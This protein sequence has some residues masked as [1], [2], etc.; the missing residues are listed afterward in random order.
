MPTSPLPIAV[1]LSGTGRSLKNLIERQQAG[2]LSTDIRLVIASKPSAGGL[3]YAQDAGIPTEVVIRTQLESDAAFGT[4][5]FNLLRSHQV[6][7]VVLAGFMKFVPIP[8]DFENRVINIHPSLIP[9]FCGPGL[10]G[11]HVHQ[12]VLDYGVKVTGCTVHFV[13]NQYDHGPVILQRTTTVQE[14]DTAETLAARVFALELAALPKAIEL[15]A[16]HRI[17]V[18]GRLVRI[19]PA[20]KPD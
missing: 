10:Y 13:N 5:I 7:L 4:A 8:P 2:A 19:M 20:G 1:L 16:T 3:Q 17:H 9:S 18:A 11:Q 6:E 14:D 12:A 15:I